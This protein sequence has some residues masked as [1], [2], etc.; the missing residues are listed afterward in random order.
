MTSLSV[1]ARDSSCTLSASLRSLITAISGDQNLRMDGLHHT[2][3]AVSAI[4]FR[5]RALVTNTTRRFRRP[6]SWITRTKKKWLYSMEVI[7]RQVKEW[8]SKGRPYHFHISFMTCA[9]VIFHVW[10]RLEARAGNC[11]DN[12]NDGVI[13]REIAGCRKYWA[14]PETYYT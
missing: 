12:D 1:R 14:R 8:L 7:R 9:E 4:K 5:R 11:R 10:S 13:N 2:V 3:S 6:I